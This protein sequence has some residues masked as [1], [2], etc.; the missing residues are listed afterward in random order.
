MTPPAAL[1]FD[2]GGTLDAD[3]IPWKDRFFALVS[4]AGVAVEPEAFDRAF[5]AADDAL[6]GRLPK[7][8]ALTETVERL[9]GDLARSLGQGPELAQSIAARFLSDALSKLDANAELLARLS[10]RYRIGVVSNFYGNLEAICSGTSIGRYVEVAVDS[11]AVGAEKPDPRI[12]QA[13]LSALDTDPGRAVFIGD[14]L[15]RDMEGARRLGMPHVWL[16][17]RATQGCCPGDS[18]IAS[19]AELPGVL[20]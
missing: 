9:A 6:V 5:Y 14:S 10:P 4:E 1:L 7:E 2:F 20:P 18:V 17:P 13:A 8:L 15:P 19:L 16:A 3:G 12:F 11:Q